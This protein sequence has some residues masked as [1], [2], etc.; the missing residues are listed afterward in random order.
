MS[1]TLRVALL[2]ERDHGSPA[3]NLDAIEAGLREAAAKAEQDPTALNS[4]LRKHLNVWTSQD[5]RWMPPAKWAACNSAGPLISPK[6]LRAKAIEKL[7]GRLCYGGIDLS[8]KI[9]LTAFVLVFP[10]LK[11]I[12]TR[13]Q[14][15]Q[16]I[17][18]QRQR[19][20]IEFEVV[21]IQEADPKWY[22]LPWFFVPND[23]V[24]DRVAHDR[25]EY[26]VWIREGYI[27]ATKGNAVDQ[28]AVRTAVNEARKLFQ[29]EEIGFDS[30]NATQLANEL[31]EDGHKMVEVRQG[32]KTMSEPMKELMAL[33]LSV[34]LEHFGHPVLTW[35]A[36][37]VAAEQDPAGNIKP[38][39]EHS[40]EKIDGIVALIMA[41]HRVVTNP[42]AASQSSVYNHRGI[43]FI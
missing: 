18:E 14:K 2:Q 11:E 33:V 3:A 34:L 23:N 32:Y 12:K 8:S 17:E 7:K 9:D 24:A 10:P 41:M 6:E 26:D 13:R 36:G 43:V 38:D 19:K 27:T 40:K 21:T 4:F 39:K 5:V 29:I 16:T 22:V 1:H 20:P 35:C 25:V 37:N 31:K 28:Q 15:P 42:T 30:W